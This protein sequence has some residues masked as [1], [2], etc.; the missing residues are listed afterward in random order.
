MFR[1]FASNYPLQSKPLLHFLRFGEPLSVIPQELTRLW[2]ELATS[3]KAKFRQ[4]VQTGLQ[5]YDKRLQR[6]IKVCCQ[7]PC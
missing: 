7:I 4:R 5:E 3:T 1:Y 6:W 2:S